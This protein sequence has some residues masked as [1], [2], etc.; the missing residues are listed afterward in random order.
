MYKLK[1]IETLNMHDYTK[2]VQFFFN[3]F[4]F[5]KKTNPWSTVIKK[6]SNHKSHG[7][8]MIMCEIRNVQVQNNSN[9]KYVWFFWICTNY[10]YF[11]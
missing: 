11:I 9:I 8:C 3:F 10:S 1:I 2:F 6:N 5:F 7:T 4:N